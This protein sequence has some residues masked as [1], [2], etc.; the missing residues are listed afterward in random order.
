FKFKFVIPDS[1]RDLFI[2]FRPC[3]VL[4]SPRHK[5]KA[6]AAVRIRIPGRVSRVHEER[7]RSNGRVRRRRAKKPLKAFLSASIAL[8][9][10]ISRTTPV[11]YLG[12]HGAGPLLLDVAVTGWPHTNGSITL[13][14]VITFQLPGSQVIL[15]VKDIDPAHPLKDISPPI[16]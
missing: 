14:P 5:A 15:V 8:V 6:G 13:Y 3:S 9:A 7:A 10:I 4:R 16:L 11:I 2:F 1:F 12:Q